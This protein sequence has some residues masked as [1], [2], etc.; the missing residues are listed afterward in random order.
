MLVRTSQGN[1]LYLREL[2]VGSIDAGVLTRREGLW[3]FRGDV[4]V[5]P[6]LA[7]VVMARMAP[8]PPAQRDAME[9][10][11]IGGSLDLS[12]ASRLVGLDDLESLERAASWR[13]A[14]SHQATRWTWHTH[15]T[16][17]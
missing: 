13:S 17:N 2:V 8:L 12:F 4:R 6:Q 16:A 9:I 1:P 11:A 10:L 7:E 15:C 14:A 5:T 3:R